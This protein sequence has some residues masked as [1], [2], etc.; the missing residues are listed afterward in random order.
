MI[1][2]LISLREKQNETHQTLLKRGE[3]GEEKWKYNEK[4][5]LVQGTLYTHME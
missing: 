5:E 1:L 2:I 4:G 3:E